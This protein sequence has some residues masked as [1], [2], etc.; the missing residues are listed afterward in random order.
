MIIAWCSKLF[1][2]LCSSQGSSSSKSASCAAGKNN[3][4]PR[5]AMLPAARRN[6]KCN[7]LKKK[8]VIKLKL[9]LKLKL[10][11][12]FHYIYNPITLKTISG[13]LKKNPAFCFLKHVRRLLSLCF[14]SSENSQ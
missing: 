2:L 12:L 4:P 10:N 1:F 7:F 5:L 14:V 11:Y 13:S 6:C 8:H 9:K 3:L